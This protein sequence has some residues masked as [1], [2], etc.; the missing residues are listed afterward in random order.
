MYKLFNVH[1][2]EN[3]IMVEL[4]RESTAAGMYAH[5]LTKIVCWGD[6]VLSDFD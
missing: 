3:C 5:V 2:D 6:S 4:C 1:N